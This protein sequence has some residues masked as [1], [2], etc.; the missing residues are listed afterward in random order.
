MTMN[1]DGTFSDPTEARAYLSSLSSHVFRLGDTSFLHPDFAVNMANA[2]QQARSQGLPVTVQ[3]GY[4]T[5]DTT[6]SGYDA[7]GLSMHGYGAAIDVGGIGGPGS[8]Q[9]QQWAKI[10]ASNGV[11]NPYGVNDPKEYNHWQLTPWTLESRPD[12]QQSI[13]NAHGDIGKIWNAV[14]PV[15]Q[16]TANVASAKPMSDADI[17]A[18]W[19]GPAAAPQASGP[20]SQGGG[21]PMSAAPTPMSDADIAAMWVGP[22]KS[23]TP[24]ATPATTPTNDPRFPVQA[25]APVAGNAPAPLGCVPAISTPRSFLRQIRPFSRR[26]WT[27]RSAQTRYRRKRHPRPP[28]PI[29]TESK[30]T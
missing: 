8:P 7:S 3:S 24:S 4:R 27:R 29:S 28:S 16:G 12:V 6:G 14:S 15:S 26:E 17:A 11:Y 13:V 10:A 9:A 1:D 22:P 25:T 23:T 19:K 20:T 30:I 21:T 5:N 18:L 2:V